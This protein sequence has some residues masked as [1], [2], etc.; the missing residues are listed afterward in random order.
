MTD[1][2]SAGGRADV[3]FSFFTGQGG[4][5]PA[6]ADGTATVAIRVRNVRGAYETAGT[7]GGQPVE[8]LGIERS[9][10]AGY[11]RVLVRFTE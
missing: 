1:D 5:S 4:V 8:V 10:V 7:V 9:P 6:G 11:T 2:I 3:A